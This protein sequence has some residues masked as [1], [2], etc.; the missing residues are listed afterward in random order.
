MARRGVGRRR[1]RSGGERGGPRWGGGGVRVGAGGSSTAA[2]TRRSRAGGRGVG[3]DGG[4]TAAGLGGGG[5]A[6]DLGVGGDCAREGEG[7]AAATSRLGGCGVEY[8]ATPTGGPSTPPRGVFYYRS[9][10]PG[11]RASPQ[12]YGWPPGDSWGAPGSRSR[13][14]RASAT[15]KRVAPIPTSPVGGIHASAV[16][17]DGC[18]MAA[19]LQERGARRTQA[20]SVPPLPLMR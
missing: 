17:L 1:G 14:P 9:A 7:M 10:A 13:A 15:P 18:S 2:T 4:G 20:A 5:K 11:A 6:A 8:P 12:S 16:A 3:L 19:G